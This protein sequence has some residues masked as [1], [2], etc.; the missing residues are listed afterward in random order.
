[1]ETL[2]QQDLAFIQ[3]T[4]FGDFSRGA[5]PE[6]VQLLRACEIPVRRVVEVGCG[7]GPLSVALVDAGFE[8]QGIDVSPE[9]LRIA[10]ATCAKARFIE[11][12][13]YEQELPPCEAILALGEPL[14]YHETG[15]AEVRVREF[16]QRAADILP[17]G[18][19]LI[20][21]L[22]ELGEP[23]LVGR[24]WSAGE[25]WAVL[26]ETKEDQSA[27]TLVRSIETFRKVGDLY[28]RARE[29]HQVRLFD[30]SEVCGWLEA[31]GFHV[32]TAPRYG[33]YQL[34]P[35]RQAFFCRRRRGE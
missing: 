31:A 24:F 32:S 26:S 30:S 9:L 7:A 29:V 21:D 33:K 4:G 22:I 11:G 34:A 12:S 17:F 16:F 35:R 5:A 18:G 14:T 28:R 3:A 15:A 2:Y 23:S 8:V 1:M 19:M 10:Q 13:V 25:D 20:F 6:I 27:R